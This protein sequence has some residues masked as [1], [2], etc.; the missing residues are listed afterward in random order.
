MKKITKKQAIQLLKE[1]Y[2]ISLRKKLIS[3]G[4]LLAE[5]DYSYKVSEINHCTFILNR[6]SN[7]LSGINIETI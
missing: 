7:E 3:D 2:R 1:Y 6:I 4:I 5:L